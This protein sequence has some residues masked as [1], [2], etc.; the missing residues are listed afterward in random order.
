MAVLT[1]SHLWLSRLRVDV[2]IFDGLG[3]L[4]SW[5]PVGVMVNRALI[6]RAMAVGAMTT[7][8]LTV[9]VSVFWP[10]LFATHHAT[11]NVLLRAIPATR[12]V[13]CF[14]VSISFFRPAGSLVT[15]RI[16]SFMPVAISRPF[17]RVNPRAM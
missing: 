4:Y 13:C 14:A 5:L 2:H 10:A 1:G 11:G 7:K 17:L 8:A 15:V 3:L 9:D 6:R 12:Y 16:R